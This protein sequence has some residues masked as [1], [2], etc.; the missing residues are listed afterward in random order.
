MDVAVPDAAPVA[1]WRGLRDHVRMTV[2]LAPE[3]VLPIQPDGE[4]LTGHSIVIDDS[5]IT[6]VLPE[7]EAAQNYPTAS[8]IPLPGQVVIPGLV[9][10]HTHA[11]MTLLRGYADDLPL[12]EWLEERIWPTEGKWVDENFVTDGTLIACWEMLTGG[13]TTFND[14]YFFPSEAVAA[15]RRAG[16]RIVAGIT[17]VAAP[18][19]YA[20]TEHESIE[21]GVAALER[22]RDEPAVSFM[23]APHSTYAA[24][25]GSWERAGALAD[26]LGVGVHTHLNETWG[27]VE[28]HIAHH[29]RPSVRW[30]AD[31]NALAPH[32]LAAHAV[33]MNHHD[34]ELAAAHGVCV[35]HCP[36]SNLKLASGFAKV[37]RMLDNGITVGLGTDGAASNNRLDLFQEMR[38]AALL[39]KAVAKDGAAVDAHTALRMATL[40]GARCLGLAD[41]IGSITPG[42]S[43][44]L[45]SVDLASARSS[46]LYDVASHLVYVC[47]RDDVTNVWVRGKRVVSDRRCRT[48]T[49][50]EVRDLGRSWQRRI[51]GL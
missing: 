43:A 13:T 22:W 15:A 48:V 35:S 24:S 50:D 19:R 38:T 6:A 25:V 4:V 46:P 17:Y 8:V 7:A 5:R 29:R 11:A 31:H 27:E 28:R 44:D 37:Q 40:D 26:Q 10:T 20:G 39:A 23:L 33:H 41:E 9:N 12:L 34:L 2:R 47:S 36:S 3:W 32:F 42:K 45:V 16:A 49:Q 14:M 21:R 18:N 51:A 1:F 30:L